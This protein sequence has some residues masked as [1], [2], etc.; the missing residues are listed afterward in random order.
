MNNQ[1]FLSLERQDGKVRPVRRMDWTEWALTIMVCLT[2][3]IIPV[4]LAVDTWTSY[5][6][7]FGICAICFPLAVLCWLVKVIWDRETKGE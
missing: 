5:G 6:A 7:F 3:E 2:F 1:L 4:M